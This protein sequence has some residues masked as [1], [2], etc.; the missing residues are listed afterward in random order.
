MSEHMPWLRRAAN[1]ECILFLA[2][3]E[4]LSCAPG[5]LDG[6]VGEVH[7]PLDAADGDDAPLD[8]G[9]GVVLVDDLSSDIVDYEVGRNGARGLDLEPPVEGPS[10]ASDGLRAI[11]FSLRDALLDPHGGRGRPRGR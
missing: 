7:L 4:K 5:V 3:H 2:A 9:G 8:P 11:S 10:E 6:D 1:R